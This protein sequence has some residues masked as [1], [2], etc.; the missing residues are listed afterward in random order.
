MQQDSANLW[1]QRSFFMS[2]LKNKMNVRIV[3]L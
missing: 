1:A 2:D 3:H